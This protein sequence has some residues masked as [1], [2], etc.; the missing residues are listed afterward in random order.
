ML[1]QGCKKAEWLDGFYRKLQIFDITYSAKIPIYFSEEFE[2]DGV[3]GMLRHRY[4]YGVQSV[5]WSC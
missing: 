3:N 4:I 2:D 5:I 1:K